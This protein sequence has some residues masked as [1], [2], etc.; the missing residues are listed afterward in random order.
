MPPHWWRADYT[1][2]F[3]LPQYDNAARI[4]DSCSHDMSSAAASIIMEAQQA[5]TA[6][7]ILAYAL[8][9]AGTILFGNVV[10]LGAAWL[11]LLGKF[12]GGG[13]VLTVCVLLAGHLSGDMIWYGMGRSFSGT[14]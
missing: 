14:P 12:G 4:C 9:Y 10:V 1:A 11:A 5:Y 6:H 3:P 7:P 13:M 2:S 8:I